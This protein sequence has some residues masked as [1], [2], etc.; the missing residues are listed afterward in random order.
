MV[1]GQEYQTFAEN[2]DTLLE[3]HSGKFALIYGDKMIGVWDSQ[4]S[5]YERGVREFGNVPFLVKLIV[6]DDVIE[7][8]PAL[9]AG[10]L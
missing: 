4:A 2:K 8:A 10:V 1:L 5:A 6:Q 7:A 3:H 9:F